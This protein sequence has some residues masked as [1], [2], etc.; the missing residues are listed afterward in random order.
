MEALFSGD[1]L[2]R[3]GPGATGRSYSDF[4]TIVESI[5]RKLL[6][7][8]GRTRVHPGHGEDTSIGSEAIDLQQW[9]QRGH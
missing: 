9:I 8:P 7:L 1:T 6:A 4:P 5:R 3:G 2:F